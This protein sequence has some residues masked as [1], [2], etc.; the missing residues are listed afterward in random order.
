MKHIKV[1]VV[2]SEYST[3]YLEVPDDFVAD[4]TTLREKCDVDKAVK[5]QLEDDMCWEKDKHI[6]IDAVNFCDEKEAQDYS[7]D[8]IE[9]FAKKKDGG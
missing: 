5:T 6:T 1:E 4:S 2:R 9:Q 3:L 7:C 8:P